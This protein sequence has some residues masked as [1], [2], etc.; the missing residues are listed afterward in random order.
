MAQT[1]INVADFIDKQKV[2]SFQTKVLFLCMAVL[3]MDGYDTQVIGYLGPSLATAMKVPPA[4]LRPVFLVALVGLMIGGLVCGP[5]ADRFGRKTFV[6][7][8]TL[9]FGVLSLATAWA[10]SVE[11]LIVLRF[12]TGLG[13][14]GA[15]PNAVSLGI[16]YFPKSR[17]AFITSS[18]WVGFSTGAAI[19]GFVSAALLRAGGWQSVF[20]VGGIVPILLAIVQVVYLPESLRFLVLRGGNQPRIAGLLRRVAPHTPIPSDSVFTSSEEHS[21]GQPVVELFRNGRA[22]GTCVLWIISFLA[23]AVVFL[24]TSWLPIAFNQGGLP[25]SQSI[26]ALTMYQVG[27]IVGALIIGRMMDSFDR[28]Y[29]LTGAFLISGFCVLTLSYISASV[30]IWVLLALMVF[31]GIFLSAGGTPG[32]NALTGT[33]FPT[34]MRSTGI[35]WTLGAGRIGSLFGIWLGGALI[36]AKFSVQAIFLYVT[37]TAFVCAILVVILRVATQ[38]QVAVS[39]LVEQLAAE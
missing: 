13:L 24:M 19:A 9:T 6:V 35:G 5:L 17:K 7:L 12:L 2:G 14:G 15:M 16:E 20:M 29:V 23:L 10:W 36:A 25:E 38:R 27:A 3:F 30:P 22:P 1:T 33:Y 8:S 4:E 26:L 34:H 28:F 31:N 37:F 11:S 18:V 32:V 21:S 39:G